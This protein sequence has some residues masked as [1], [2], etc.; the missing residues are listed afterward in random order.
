MTI[1]L[2][3][4]GGV[5]KSVGE[6]DCPRMPY[7]IGITGQRRV[8]KTTV[9]DFL[10]QLGVPVIDTDHLAAELISRPGPT[11]QA[12]RNRFGSALFDADGSIDHNLL[13][14]IASEH[15]ANKRDLE[16]I[17]AN[18]TLAEL[19]NRIAAM[20]DHKVVAVIVSKLH[21]GGWKRQFN[22]NW[23]VYCD[24][25]ELL[26]RASVDGFTPDQMRLMMSTQLPQDQK[27]G[28]SDCVIDNTNS[29]EETR[30]M[31]QATLGEALERASADPSEDTT[32][33]TKP[34][35]VER[36]G[37]DDQSH[38]NCDESDR[39]K[40]WLDSFGKLGIEEVLAR[41][42]DIAHVGS[43]SASTTST[44]RIDAVDADASPMA[45]E[46][47]VK[48][49]MSVRNKKGG[50]DL[51]PKCPNQ[52]VPPVPPGP[53][54]NPPS[55]PSDGGDKGKRRPRSLVSIVA[56]F[57]IVVLT[58]AGLYSLL[59][60]PVVNIVNQTINQVNVVVNNGVTVPGKPPVI[61]DGT[62]RAGS[63][64]SF[65]S[66]PGKSFHFMP[67]ASRRQVSIWEATFSSDCQS[68]SLRGLDSGRRQ[69][70]WQLFNDAYFTN[71]SYQYITDYRITG[72]ISVDRYDGPSNTFSGRTVYSYYRGSRA[73]VVEQLDSG[74]RPIF[75][76]EWTS[77][78]T[79]CVTEYDRSSGRVVRTYNLDGG[80]AQSFLSGGTFLYSLFNQ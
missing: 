32:G 60:D 69:I 37:S 44:M 36:P 66:P 76:A 38:D 73:S 7:V 31:V 72:S 70:I 68:V 77:S 18:R 12:I 5:S 35:P 28:L 13:S 20:T 45:R 40:K 47:E 74:Q 19:Q 39:L 15:P 3:H 23:C 6:S 62:C 27:V 75:K 4:A 59:R 30:Q 14:I 24:E 61:T 10:L 55:P 53:P 51:P 79:L 52:P 9:G 17:L 25:G 43:R 29:R 64:V 48:V 16:A 57:A 11:Q 65:S 42:G 8:G 58:V 49:E 67:N 22:E 34:G 80:A 2:P 1:S 46:L 54:T 63:T 26:Q 33:D 41:L 56:I 50:S 78:T 71:L 21:E